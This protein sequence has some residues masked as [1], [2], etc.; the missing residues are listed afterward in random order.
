MD[1]SNRAC[2]PN[3]VSAGQ[4]AG[5]NAVTGRDDSVLA[6]AAFGAV[7]GAA[8]SGVGD[9]IVELGA[10]ATKR[11]YNALSTS[12]KLFAN[13][14]VNTNP[15]LSLAGARPGVVAG[16]NVISN[17]IGASIPSVISE[18]NASVSPGATIGRG[19]AK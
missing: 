18:A 12:Q 17:A 4:T 19:T 8:G 14:F 3:A 15:G 10:R 6:A 13:M 5:V 1:R 7:G 11:S 2:S 9:A 16:A